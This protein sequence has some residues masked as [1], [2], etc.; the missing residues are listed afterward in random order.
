MTSILRSIYAANRAHHQYP[1]RSPC[2]KLPVHLTQVPVPKTSHKST[3]NTPNTAPIRP[4]PR[5]PNHRPQPQPAP[6]LP[7]PISTSPRQMSS[8][9]PHTS[10][11][12]S[13][14]SRR[15]HA[16]SSTTPTPNPKANNLKDSSSPTTTIDEE[17][18][19]RRRREELSFEEREDRERAAA[20]LRSWECCAWLGEGRGEVSF[21]SSFPFGYLKRVVRH[22]KG[23]FQDVMC[24]LSYLCFLSYCYDPPFESHMKISTF[25]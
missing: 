17:Q 20:V 8:P 5:P 10:S 13:S 6:H 9:K 4:S 22:F 1:F 11:S 14:S 7:S 18:I 3:P 21:F 25:I 24:I 23:L 12:S 15:H 2:P 19:G 16:S